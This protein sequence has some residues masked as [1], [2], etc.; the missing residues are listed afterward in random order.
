MAGD[1]ITIRL[2]FA[3]RRLLEK[4]AAEMGFSL[5]EAARACIASRYRQQELVQ[6]IQSIKEEIINNRVLTEAVVKIESDKIL[7]W[8]HEHVE[9]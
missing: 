9:R 7:N 6:E 3:E 1:R 5:S 8:L 4:M 2:T